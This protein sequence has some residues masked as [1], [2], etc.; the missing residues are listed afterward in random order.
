MYREL[1][2]ESCLFYVCRFF[3]CVCVYVC[4]CVCENVCVCVCVFVCVALHAG[5]CGLLIKTSFPELPPR[6]RASFL[7]GEMKRSSTVLLGGDFHSLILLTRKRIVFWVAALQ[8]FY[9][10]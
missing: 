10:K 5:G 2:F 1:W 7:V 8:Y 4:V 6:K 9:I 3:C